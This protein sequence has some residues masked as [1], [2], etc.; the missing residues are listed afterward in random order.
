MISTS[1]LSSYKL[2]AEDGKA[3]SVK[4]ILFDDGRWTVRHFVVDTGGLLSKHKVILDPMEALE[5]DPGEKVLP[6]RLTRDEVKRHPIPESDPPL[7]HSTK[8]SG[9]DA[10][11]S[12]GAGSMIGAGPAEIT[13]GASTPAY[14]SSYIDP[15]PHLRSASDVQDYKLLTGTD[16]VGK[17]MDFV[18][19]P[20]SW[21]VTHAVIALDDDGSQR[22]IPTE[23]ISKI[24]FPEKVVTTELMP[25]V[26]RQAQPF[27]GA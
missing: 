22:L 23:Q 20:E 3:G 12:S 2:Q 8:R 19:D 5:P 25:D 14:E 18:I 24:G 13:M 1:E 16:E 17:V 26:L 11:R 10:M 27:D 15:D 6:V 7:S 21:K 4:D 9:P